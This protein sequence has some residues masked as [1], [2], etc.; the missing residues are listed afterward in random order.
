MSTITAAGYYQQ[1]V[2]D[3][4][5]EPA[6]TRHD[7]VCDV[8]S[9]G[10]KVKIG[11]LAA[12]NRLDVANCELIANGSQAAMN[13]DVCVDVDA[14]TLFNDVALTAATFARSASTA[15]QLGETL[16]VDYEKDRDIYLLINSG[17]ATAPAG[18]KLTLKLAQ[19]PVPKSS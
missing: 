14:N 7:W 1:A 13:V 8:R 6:F 2:S 19:Y 10:D 3:G 4:A 16:G 12:G 5:G 17:A 11:R 15:Y 18:G 9:A